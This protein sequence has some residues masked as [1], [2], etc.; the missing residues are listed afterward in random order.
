M[1]SPQHP[2]ATDADSAQLASLGYQSEFR[3]DMS[4]WANF[5]LGFTYLSPVVGIYSV[6]GIALAMAGPPMIWSLLIVGLGQWLVSLVFGEIVSQYPIAG[7]VYP[8]A[9]RLWGTRWAWMTG[10]VYNWALL[11]TIAGV[12]F[13][14]GVY[15]SALLGLEPSSFS[16]VICGI[17][18]IGFATVVNLLGTR[19]LAFVALLGFAAELLGALFVGGWLLLF[20]QH[21]GFAALFDSFGAAS[22]HGSDYLPLFLGASIIG[23][24]QYY[25]FEACGDVAEEVQDPTRRIPRSMR[26]TIYI[27]GAAATF[28]CFALIAAV[29]DIGAVLRGEVADPVGAIMG[30][31][32]GPVGTRLVY[33]VV[34][35]SF[36]SCVLSLQAA[37]SRLL[38]AFG[39]D[40]MIAGGAWLAH[41]DHVRHVPPYALLVACVLP[42]GMVVLSLL[43]ESALLKMVSW[44]SLGIYIAFQMVVLAALRAR[45]RGWQPSGAFRLGAWGL[46]V[47][48]AA[49][50]Y[51]VC[52]ITVI[53]WPWDASLVWYDKYFLELMS[54]GG[55][56]LGYAYMRVTS[57]HARVDAPAGDALAS[58]A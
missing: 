53:A 25:G 47:N 20:H 35:L 2:S 24:F 3:R 29:P 37:A 7:G 28:V 51:G 55:L 6:F 46:P 49:L 50:A 31:A 26:L 18:M 22:I 38:Y 52:A 48:L 58:H 16:N 19:V 45:L 1:S 30:D 36:I 34:L 41:F 14:S 4:M 8:W 21:Q 54:I 10:W 44:A 39:R 15:L 43:S 5:A 32:F 23:I 40:R 17:G 27:G 11:I 56:L 13:S 9:R 57:V 33:A 12:A 42:M